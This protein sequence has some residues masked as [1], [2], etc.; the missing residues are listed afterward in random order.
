[1]ECNGR[2]GGGGFVSHGQHHDR[3]KGLAAWL[4]QLLQSFRVLLIQPLKSPALCQVRRVT[5][6]SVLYTSMCLAPSPKPSKVL[7]RIAPPKL[8]EGF[9]SS[10]I[11]RCRE[12]DQPLLD[13]GPNKGSPKFLQKLNWT[14]FMENG[15]FYSTSK[16]VLPP[17]AADILKVSA[18]F[19]L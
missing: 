10:S 18:I 5:T 12:S 6:L 4:A 13:D 1:M 2:H 14:P 11:S 16:R 9:D 19:H 17:L 8:S 15:F 7:A 3:N